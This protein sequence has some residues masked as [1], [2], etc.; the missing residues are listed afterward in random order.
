MASKTKSFSDELAD[1]YIGFAV[2]LNRFMDGHAVRE[3]IAELRSLEVILVEQ[4]EAADLAG[5][6]IE[7]YKVR[8]LQALLQ[9]TKETIKASYKK[10]SK[11]HKTTLNQ[12]SKIQAEAA[13]GMANT[14]A[15]F[16]LMTVAFT[17][18]DYKNIVTGS[19]IEGHPAEAWWAKQG[20]N[21]KHAFEGQLRQGLLQAETNQELVQRIRGRATGRRIPITTSKGSTIVVNEYAGGIMDVPRHQAESL[22]RTSVQSVSNRT[23]FETYKENQDVLK[24]FELLVTLDGRTSEIC[25]ARSGGAWDFQGDPLPQ[26]AVDMRFPGEPPYH[27]RCRSILLP[28]TFSFDEIISTKRFDGLGD[29]R[30]NLKASMDGTVSGIKTFE[31]WLKTKDVEFQKEK[32]G[33]G[34]WQLWS[35][36]KITLAQLVDGRGNPLTL[37]QLEAIAGKKKY[38]RNQPVMNPPAK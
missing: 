11:L 5:Y 26:S 29:T 30:P 19:L 38:R 17:G 32:L 23:L 15:D 28:I 9:Q 18:T 22:V 10:V 4:I 3:V 21:L 1:E 14:I 34:K 33:P 31:Q 7:S 25:M 8:R 2:D 16:E 27:F 24:G 6:A 13:V 36:G 37:Q 35:K 20:D 12:L